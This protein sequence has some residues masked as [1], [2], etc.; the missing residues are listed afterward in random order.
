MVQTQHATKTLT[1][2]Q[3]I[4]E[5]LAR[6]REVRGFSVVELARRAGM[7]KSHLGKVL[8]GERGLRADELVCLCYALG[9]SMEQLIPMELRRELDERCMRMP[10]G[11]PRF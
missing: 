2:A 6:M 3:C 11:S 10:D 7:D 8:R 5:R 1:H 9:V 4:T